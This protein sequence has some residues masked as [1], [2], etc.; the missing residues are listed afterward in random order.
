MIKKLLS[1]VCCVLPMGV[2]AAPQE[3]APIGADAA[4]ATTYDA[5][6]SAIAGGQSIVVI[7]GNGINA[8][9]GTTTGGNTVNPGFAVANNMIVGLQNNPGTVDVPPIDGKVNNL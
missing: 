5:W 3:I 2:R 1:L 6:Q 7:G 9:G 8:T 4:V